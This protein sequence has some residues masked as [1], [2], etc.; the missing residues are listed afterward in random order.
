MKCKVLLLAGRD[1]RAPRAEVYRLQY[2]S[3]NAPQPI[4]MDAPHQLSTKPGILSSISTDELKTPTDVYVVEG[5]IE[6]HNLEEIVTI[7][8]RP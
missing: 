6:A 4:R 3:S 5:N 8:P 1:I 2:T 7:S